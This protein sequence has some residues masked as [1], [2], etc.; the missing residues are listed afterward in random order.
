MRSSA[1]PLIWLVQ[2]LRLCN[3]NSLFVSC[4]RFHLGFAFFAF[5]CL[6]TL[7]CSS[8]AREPHYPSLTSSYFNQIHILIQNNNY[9]SYPL[10]SKEHVRT[11]TPT[12]LYPT[13]IHWRGQHVAR[14]TGRQH[15][16]SC[17]TSKHHSVQDCV[18]LGLQNNTH[19][20]CSKP[21]YSC[22]LQLTTMVITSSCLRS[23]RFATR[24]NKN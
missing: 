21:Q 17:Y 7:K 24:T 16:R 8:F 14:R 1:P 22:T 15:V 20:W 11:W 3:H 2:T 4:A 5:F 10:F 6:C 12:Q 13:N 23:P 18:Q 19:S 9:S